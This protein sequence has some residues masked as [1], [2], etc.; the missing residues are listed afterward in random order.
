MKTNLEMAIEAGF[1]EDMLKLNGSESLAIKLIEIVKRE[2][3]HECMNLIIQDC[4]SDG[5]DYEIITRRLWDKIRTAK[6]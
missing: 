3:K 6:I 2:S 4:P 1:D 5:S